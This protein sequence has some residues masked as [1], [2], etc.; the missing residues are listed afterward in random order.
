MCNRLTAEYQYVNK[1]ATLLICIIREF[2]E[3]TYEVRKFKSHEIVISGKDDMQYF[4]TKKD[5]H[6]KMC[7]LFGEIVTLSEY[8]YKKRKE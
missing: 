5:C 7:A 4:S 8:E 6:D 3:W 1:T 2:R